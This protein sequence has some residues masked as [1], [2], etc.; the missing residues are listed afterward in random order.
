MFT[1]GNP[2]KNQDHSIQ[3]GTP[4]FNS[5]QN[6][7]K[8]YKKIIVK[9]NF[10]QQRSFSTQE[11]PNIMNKRHSSSVLMPAFLQKP[12]PVKPSDIKLS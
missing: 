6:L 3:K 10:K 12:N 11:A 9:S 2:I 1:L 8:Q 4:T 7:Q 5:T